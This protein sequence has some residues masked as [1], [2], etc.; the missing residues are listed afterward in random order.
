VATKLWTRSP[1]SLHFPKPYCNPNTTCGAAGTA[2]MCALPGDH[3]NARGVV[4]A[5]PSTS[6]MRPSGLEEIVVCAGTMP[7]LRRTAS[8]S[9]A[10][11]PEVSPMGIPGGT[12]SMVCLP[13][14]ANEKGR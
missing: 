10:V 7:Y 5:S 13:S 4:T 11:I 9:P 6:M 12:L 2:I 1:P 14:T 3:E 8:K